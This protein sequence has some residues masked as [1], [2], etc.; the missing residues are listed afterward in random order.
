VKALQKIER[1]TAK[2]APVLA[3]KD[4]FYDVLFEG[5]GNDALRTVI[6]GL[7]ARVNMLRSLSLS[8]PGRPAESVAELRA[9]VD[10][11]LAGDADAAARACSRHVEE[12]GRIGLQALASQND[13]AC[14]VPEIAQSV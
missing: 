1:L 5:G 3:A 11:V 10:A 2:D 6:E 7:Y 14:R 9:I 12:A 8:V 13:A 4:A